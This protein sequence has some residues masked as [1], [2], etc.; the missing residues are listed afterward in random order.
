VKVRVPFVAVRV[1]SVPPKDTPEMVELVRPELLRV[2]VVE[3]VMV[4]APPEFVTELPRVSPLNDCV[5][6]AKESVPVCAEPYV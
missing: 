1:A 3:G 4:N 2:P 5:D 6:V